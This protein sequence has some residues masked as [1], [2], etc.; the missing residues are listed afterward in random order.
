V[1]RFSLFFLCLVGCSERI[2]PDERAALQAL[3]A[4]RQEAK[5]QVTDTAKANDLMEQVTAWL[6]SI[7]ETQPDDLRTGLMF[8][9]RPLQEEYDRRKKQDGYLSAATWY[10][11]EVV[12]VAAEKIIAKWR[13]DE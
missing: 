3:V 5:T 11:G 2:S 4:A 7:P 1:W 13:P 9:M 6:E 10:H 8:C 12:G